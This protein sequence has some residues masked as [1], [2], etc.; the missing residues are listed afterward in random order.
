MK[1]ESI[2]QEIIK[3]FKGN[4]IVHPNPMTS[5]EVRMLNT[6]IEYFA[7]P[8]SESKGTAEDA[9]SILKDHFN[10]NH[11]IWASHTSATIVLCMLEFASRPKVEQPISAENY[12]N[13][14]DLVYEYVLK[15]EEIFVKQDGDW[16][17]RAKVLNI[18]MNF[19]SKQQ[20]I[21]LRKELK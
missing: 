7:S 13:T 15:I 2:K 21:D 3:L 10:P 11:D 9:L 20:P 8:Q 6:C 17:R 1:P 4:D 16:N 14:S 5:G 18:L 12:E 19:V